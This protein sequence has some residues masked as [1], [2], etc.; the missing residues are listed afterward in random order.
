MCGLT[1]HCTAIVHQYD[2]PQ[3]F[4]RGAV[5]NRH[6]SPEQRGPVLLEERD[7]DADCGK[8]LRV[9]LEGASAQN[10]SNS[11]YSPPIMRRSDAAPVMRGLR[12]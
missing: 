9:L 8:T 11:S 10:N 1:L 12:R 5:H 3:D 7:D 4:R 2:L 6:H